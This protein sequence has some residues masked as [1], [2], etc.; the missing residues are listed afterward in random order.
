MG[1]RFC[2]NARRRGNRMLPSTDFPRKQLA[3]ICSARRAQMQQR[4]DSFGRGARRCRAQQM[5]GS[6]CD[7]HVVAF[8]YAGVR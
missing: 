1:Q 6:E 5:A 3:I 2:A 8:A 4:G 7:V